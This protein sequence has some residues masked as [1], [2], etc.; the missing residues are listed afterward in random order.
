[1]P[2]Y[3][4]RCSKCQV[5]VDDF[6]PMSESGKDLECPKCGKLMDREYSSG[7]FQ[8]P[9]M[10]SFRGDGLTLEHINVEGEGPLTFKSKRKL[11]EYCEKH[12]LESGAL[13]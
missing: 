13:L 9:E 5:R 10:N 3:S 12:G 7:S 4:H 2:L 11:R 6:R 8:R 1:M